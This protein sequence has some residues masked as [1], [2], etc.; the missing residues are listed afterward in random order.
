MAI[1]T[2]TAFDAYLPS[3]SYNAGAVTAALAAANEMLETYTGRNFDSTA[4]TEW[5]YVDGS[6]KLF[7]D[8]YPVT[9]ITSIDTADEESGTETDFADVYRIRRNSG[10]ITLPAEM[11][12]WFKVVYTAGYSTIP[13]DLTLVANELTKAILDNTS[14]DSA[15]T[16]EK[17][18]DYSYKLAASGTNPY[19]PILSKADHYKRRV[20]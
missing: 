14:K 17:I 5:K 19:A 9:A 20:I 8:N 13:A 4:Y 18:G 3:H 16:E 15:V 6:D 12:T 1:T 10:V 11:Y 7:L 2:Q